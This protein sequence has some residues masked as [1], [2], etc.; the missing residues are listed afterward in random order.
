M[1]KNLRKRGLFTFLFAA[2]MLSNPLA[3]DAQT[4]GDWRTLTSGRSW[5]NNV[6]TSSSTWQVYNASTQTW[7]FIAGEPGP[8]LNVLIRDGV[9]QTANHSN[10]S[11]TGNQINNLFIGEGGSPIA[12]ATISNQTLTGITIVDAGSYIAIPSINIVGACTTTATA[13]ISSSK[14]TGVAMTSVGGT[15]AGGTAYTT[16]TVTIGTAWA[17]NTAYTIGAQRVNAG[18]LY[19]A[20]TAGT[21]GTEG[22][23]STGE[24][25]N[26]GTVVWK[27]TGPNA[28]AT[29]TISGGSV[30][31]II[32][33]TSGSGYTSV[34][35][36]T[37][38]GDGTGANYAAK[39]GVEAI[40]ITNPGAG[41][42]TIPDV[43]MGANL[44]I[45]TGRRMT[46][47]ADVIF[48]KGAYITNP[49][50]STL[51]VGANLSAV[52]PISFRT[53][54]A[55]L[56]GNTNVT[57]SHASIMSHATTGA[58]MT[59]NNL[60]IPAG[61]T[62]TV[63]NE[64]VVLGTLTNN[65]TIDNKGS[66]AYSAIAGT[67]TYLGNTALGVK[68]S[69]FT[70]KATPNIIEIAWATESEENSDKFIVEK[71]T[72]GVSFTKMAEVKSKGASSY[73]VNDNNPSN[74]VNYYRLVQFDT[75]GASETFG[76]VS[77][78]FSLNATSSFAVYPNPTNG[79]ISFNAEGLVGSV[80]VALIDMQGRII[81]AETVNSISS[82]E[83]K[84]NFKQ[85]PGP[86]QYILQ[87]T[88][89][90]VKKTSKVIIL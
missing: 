76:P 10:S 25:I 34:P 78:N 56:T 62:L 42:N 68:L 49:G 86:G 44:S 53:T 29:A 26:D 66:I 47:M 6:A 79:N 18:N 4:D 90:G 35:A 84:V 31:G 69:S 45:N 21:S 85:Q 38:S 32:I 40:T 9:T 65:G 5:Y 23:S 60:T 22:P 71:S 20:T 50:T 87:I 11:P 51:T 27:Y 67:G 43:S 13:T 14:V 24:N 46:S 48:A 54:N 36:L 17:A 77:A 55:T 83:H 58:K 59:F 63:N 72:D 81:H 82:G 28:T 52:N 16:A 75:N 1:K 8:T 89:N 39:M 30:T 33:N 61:H 73:S 88:N 57:F 15:I 2:V 37:I 64:I 80:S 74:G 7:S 19:T 41:Y 70:A 3:T 12:T